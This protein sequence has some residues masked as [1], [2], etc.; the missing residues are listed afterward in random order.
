MDVA[1]KVNLL[2]H[3]IMQAV[4]TYL[5]NVE[6]FI[7]NSYPDKLFVLVDFI[8]NAS[9]I[10]FDRKVFDKTNIMIVKMLR[11]SVDMKRFLE[12]NQR[13]A[14]SSFESSVSVSSR[15]RDL[16]SRNSYAHERTRANEKI[17]AYGKPKRPQLKS[18][19]VKSPYDAPQE[20]L[21]TR[22]LKT[23]SR[24]QKMIPH[25][26]PSKRPTPATKSTSPQ[27][28]KSISNIST[29]VE[30]EIPRGEHS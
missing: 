3:A 22:N 26:P 28:R 27:V 30:K 10:C 29:M 17:S 14:S 19:K 1:T 7:Y 2:F 4:Q 16:H 23:L 25:P 18:M 12:L 15:S 8:I 9:K 13:K 20:N 6:M 21:H 5:K 11:K 24:G